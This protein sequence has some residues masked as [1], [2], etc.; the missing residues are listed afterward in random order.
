VAQIRY[1][2]EVSMTGKE[3]ETE[4]SIRFDADPL[5]GLSSLKTTASQRPHPTA[6]HTASHTMSDIQR[7]SSMQGNNPVSHIPNVGHRRS[8]MPR[9]SIRVPAEILN[10]LDGEAL[11]RGCSISQIV[12]ELLHSELSDIKD[13]KRMSDK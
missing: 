6:M 10:A 3:P 1:T 7:Q 13:T 5:Y 4:P 9:I 8:R 12:R 2:K 11:E